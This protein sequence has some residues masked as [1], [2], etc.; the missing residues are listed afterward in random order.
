MESRKGEEH[1]CL[2][3]RKINQTYTGPTQHIYYI[4]MYISSTQQRS[5][6]CTPH[7]TGGHVK[8]LGQHVW[9]RGGV[10]T[11]FRWENLKEGDQLKKVHCSAVC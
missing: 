6:L 4:Y 9:G 11:G 3:K 8:M 1:S 2:N 7:Q 5:M 10:C